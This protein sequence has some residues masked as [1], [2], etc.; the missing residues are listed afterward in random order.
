M[1]RWGPFAHVCT[2]IAGMV[3]HAWFIGLQ[4]EADG[5]AL[6]C[7]EPGSIIAGNVLVFIGGITFGSAPLYPVINK[8]RRELRTLKGSER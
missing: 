3:A 7:V 5:V 6:R 2:F 1:T 4:M 8:L